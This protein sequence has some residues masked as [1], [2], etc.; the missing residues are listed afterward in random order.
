MNNHILIVDDEPDIIEF[1]S[2]N[3]NQKNYKVSTAING[4]ECLKLLSSGLNPDLIIL[5]V[6]MPKLNG[7]ETCEK[8]RE[9]LKID[10]TIIIFLSAR[11]ED[12]TQIACYNAGGDDFI[13]KPIQPK[14]LIKKIETILKRRSKISKSVNNISIDEERFI[15]TCDNKE[16]QLP[17]KQ[18]QLLSLLYSKPDKVFSR[19]EIINKVWGNEYYISSRNID[20][21][22]RKIR[23]NIGSGRIKTIKGV[24]YKFSSQ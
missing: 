23:E 6:M 22:I 24:G 12:F 5:D 7:I 3:L 19:E 9:E 11:N 17:K 10:E 21:Q 13:S 2:Y 16:L 8:I 14:L 15:V 20:V 18:F 1:L 4:N